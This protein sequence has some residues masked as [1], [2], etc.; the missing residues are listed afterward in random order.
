MCG[1]ERGLFR[2]ESEFKVVETT[3]LRAH[4]HQSHVKCDDRKK[5]STGGCHHIPKN[6]ADEIKL[7][8]ITDV[9]I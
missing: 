5:D 3:K 9:G 6:G 7:A 1:R 2:G 4:T 8:H